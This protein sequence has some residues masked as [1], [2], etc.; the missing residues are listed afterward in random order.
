MSWLKWLW[1]PVT[2]WNVSSAITWFQAAI[3][4]VFFP[5]QF[6]RLLTTIG[7]IME[8]IWEFIVAAFDVIM[9]LI[10]SS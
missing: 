9:A 4:P 3:L 7:P 2:A 6:A 1:N 10:D 8:S 5:D